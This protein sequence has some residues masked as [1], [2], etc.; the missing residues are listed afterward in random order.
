MY[1]SFCICLTVHLIRRIMCTDGIRIYFSTARANP[2]K[3]END[4]KII[5]YVDR[6]EKGTC[7]LAVLAK[8]GGNHSSYLYEMKSVFL[9]FFPKSRIIF[10]NDESNR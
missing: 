3:L 4:R 9:Y 2:E 5:R 7:D 6:E 1:T 8:F 10:R